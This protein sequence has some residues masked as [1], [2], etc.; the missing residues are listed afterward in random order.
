MIGKL[1]LKKIFG[2]PDKKEFFAATN[3]TT[4]LNDAYHGGTSC[5]YAYG[6]C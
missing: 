3:P 4:P 6:I 5:L 1:I 2:V